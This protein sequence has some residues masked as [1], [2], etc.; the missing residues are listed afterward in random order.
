MIQESCPDNLR[1]LSECYR[2][3]V[4]IIQ[5]SCPDVTG[6]LSGC[7]KNHH[8]KTED[9]KALDESYMM[10]GNNIS[11]KTLD[12]N[13]DFLQIKGALDKIAINARG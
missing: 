5:E 9:E 10:S 7:Y 1:T 11:V 13:Q 4:R 6:T 3:P 2:N 12:L 8:A